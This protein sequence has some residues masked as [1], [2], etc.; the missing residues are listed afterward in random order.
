MLAARSSFDFT[1]WFRSDG[2]EVV[3]LILG[4]VLFGRLVG[5]A[6]GLITTRIDKSFR[7]GDDLVRSEDTK[8]RHALAQVISWVLLSIVYFLVGIEVLKRFGFEIGALVAPAA[9]LGAALGFGAQRIVQDL[10]AGFFLITERQYG[11]GDVVRINVSG[12]TEAAEGTV[13]AVTLRITR[14]RNMD[15]EL[16]SVP[17]GQI[18]KVT[19]LSK[20][21]ARAV[22]DVPVQPS[23]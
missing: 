1:T 4:A 21:W 18:I 8:H 15:G 12:S 19:N 17:N 2:L 6:R 11:Y 3:L 9:V 5:W 16:I 13:E 20:D 22:V 10:L 23:A 14:L 7:H